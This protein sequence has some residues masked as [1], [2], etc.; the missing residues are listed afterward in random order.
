MYDITVSV[1][2]DVNKI[3]LGSFGMQENKNAELIKAMEKAS[4]DAN[5]DIDGDDVDHFKI[6]AQWW[7]RHYLKTGHKRLAR[8]LLEYMDVR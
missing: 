7:N 2:D 1:D 8:I 5:E 6:V 4:D 3:I